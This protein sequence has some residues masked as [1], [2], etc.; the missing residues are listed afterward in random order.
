MIEF[1]V[2]VAAVATVV[3]F[4]LSRSLRRLAAAQEALATQKTESVPQPPAEP[5]RLNPIVNSQ[6]YMTSTG[7][8]VWVFRQ[9]AWALEEDRCAEGCVPGAAPAVQ[10][11]FEGQRIRQHGV[12]A[13]QTPATVSPVVN[14]QS[15]MTSTGYS[16]WVF[17]QGAWTLEED[18]CADDCVPGPAPAVHGRFEGQRIRQHGVAAS[19]IPTT[20]SPVVNSQSYMTSTGYSVWVHRQG[21]WNLE[22]NRCADGCV[23]GPAPSVQGR[24]EGQRIRQ[25]GVAAGQ[26]V[27]QPA[28]LSPVVNSQSY[29]T[30]SGYSVW[31]FQ[32]GSWSLEEDRCAVG[33]MPGPAPTVQGRFEGQR[34]RQHG[35]PA[36]L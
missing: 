10:G 2:A 11:R 24:F 6:S 15:Y 18:R 14:S 20:V 4:D 13:S 26:S 3:L 31:V 27:P 34:I 23:P 25:H 1:G 17:Q 33:C 21:T 22:E 12:A 32:H 9:G 16:V 7:Y 36:A 35:V 8:S 28:R 30:N 29:M 5:A 19:G